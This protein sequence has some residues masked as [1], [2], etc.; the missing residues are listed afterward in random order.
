MEINTGNGCGNA[1]YNAGI[2]NFRVYDNYDLNAGGAYPEANTF[3]LS[4]PFAQAKQPGSS[5]YT[6]IPMSRVAWYNNLLKGV[7]NDNEYVGIGIEV[8]ARDMQ[9]YNNTVMSQWPTAGYA[10]G[11]TVGG[12]MQDNYACIVI[13]SRAKTAYIGDSNGKT[14]TSYL[15]N[16]IDGNCLPGLQSLSVSLGPIRNTGGVLTGTATVETVEFGMQG[17]VF[18][19]DGRYVSAVMGP[20]PYSLKYGAAGL[21]S[22]LHTFT[23]TVVDAVGLLAVSGQQSVITSGGVGPKGPIAPNVD[24]AKQ[25]FDVA[26]NADDPIHAGSKGQN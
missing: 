21:S 24:P 26:G 3:G 17:A 8:G 12:S 6:S 23:V 19:V 9:I 14:T 2:A 1:T 7:V 22:G 11:G 25:D 18:A 13:P 15:R 10:F 20:G 5:V 4:A 16:R